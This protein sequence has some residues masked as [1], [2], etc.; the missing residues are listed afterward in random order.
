[1]FGDVVAQSAVTWTPSLDTE[2]YTLFLL[3]VS[4][5]WS[6]VI[7]RLRYKYDNTIVLAVSYQPCYSR[8]WRREMKFCRCVGIIHIEQWRGPTNRRAPWAVRAYDKR[9][10]TSALPSSSKGEKSGGTTQSQTHCATHT[11]GPRRG[12]TIKYHARVLNRLNA[13]FYYLRKESENGTQ[14]I[15]STPFAA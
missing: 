12:Q 14:S 15:R 9:A 13:S 7:H 5:G 1:M 6:I 10:I 11:L 2:T 4:K 3:N 8:M